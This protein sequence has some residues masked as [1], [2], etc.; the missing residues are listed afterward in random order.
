MGVEQYCVYLIVKHSDGLIQGEE[1]RH[2]SDALWRIIESLCEHPS[3][4]LNLKISINNFSQT[5]DLEGWTNF[6][7]SFLISETLLSPFLGLFFD[8]TLSSSLVTV[9]Q[10]GQESV[11]PSRKSYTT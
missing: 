9:V 1:I 3:H 4:F 8:V 11:L 7:V 10:Y 5:G 2:E 6:L